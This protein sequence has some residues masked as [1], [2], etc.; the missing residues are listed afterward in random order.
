MYSVLEN[1]KNDRLFDSNE[2]QTI[3]RNEIKILQP[4]D[5]SFFDSTHNI[6]EVFI[7]EIFHDS[8]EYIKNSK[9]KDNNAH[10]LIKKFQEVKHDYALFG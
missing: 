2:I 4:L 3:R 8:V 10:E 7:G 6:L 9:E 1:I 5:P